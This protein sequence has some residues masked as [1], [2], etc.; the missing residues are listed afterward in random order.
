MGFMQGY[1]DAQTAVL[2]NQLKQQMIEEN[3]IKLAEQQR[4]QDEEAQ[5]RSIITQ[6]A[7]APTPTKTIDL[8]Q[9]ILPGESAGIPK[10]VLAKLTKPGL[11][12]QEGLTG[13]GGMS[14]PQETPQEA[15]VGLQPEEGLTGLG[16][17]QQADNPPVDTTAP[18]QQGTLVTKT[19]DSAKSYQVALSQVE[20]VQSVAD[21][22]RKAGLPD[23]AD[24]YLEKNYKSIQSA[25][26]A[27]TDHLKNVALMGEHMAGLGNGYLEAIKQPGANKDAAWARLILQAANEGYPTQPLL[28][29]PPDQREAMANQIVE[30]AESSK[31]RARQAIAL[32]AEVGRNQRAERSNKIRVELAAARNRLTAAGQDAIQLRHQDNMG[33]KDYNA[34]KDKLK[35]TIDT[36]ETERTDVAS[37]ISNVSARLAGLRAG[38][39]LTNDTGGK[40]TKEDRIAE[41]SALQDD[42]DNLNKHRDQLTS[43]IGEYS[44]TASGLKAPTSKE[45]SPEVK[46]EETAK[47][48]EISKADAQ[49]V[50]DAVNAH[51]DALEQIKANFAKM[52]PGVPFEKYVKINPK[53]KAFAKK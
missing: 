12:P 35:F 22:L 24:K 1:L 47:P 3:K 34:T 53:S 8:G 16:G 11:I 38:T 43:T 23:Q 21:Q 25:E 26:T 49:M 19:Q 31:D 2:G 32:S 17:M 40:L 33:W 36:L 29:T 13:F 20:Q 42:L 6:N 5:A 39:I 30:N 15:P 10:E 9:G 4:T 27:K 28:T 37:Q 46:P 14:T 44:K 48:G 18:E 52:H 51:P 45:T 7:N 50:I 41:V